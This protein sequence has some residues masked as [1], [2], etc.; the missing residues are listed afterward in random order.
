MAYG[1]KGVLALEGEDPIEL[2]NCAYTFVRQV[3]EKTGE[4]A[5]GVLGGTIHAMYLDYPKDSIWEWAMN[6][7]FKNGSVK[8]KQTDE[9]KGSFIPS[10][11]VKLTEAACVHLQFSYSRH[12]GT[13]FCTKLI[14]TS[15]ESVVGDTYDWVKKDWK[16]L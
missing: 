8:V 10:E 3:N 11:E 14:I 7:K 1:Y 15:N 2:D 12:S 5:S 4:V 16:L 13:H 6:Y 9:S